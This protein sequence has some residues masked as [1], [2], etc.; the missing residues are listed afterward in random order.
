[1][2]L[3]M[4]ITLLMLCAAPSFAQDFSGLARLNIGQSQ[5]RDEAG[6]LV[7]DLY[8]SQAVPYRVLTLDNPRQLVL[9]FREVD[10]GEATQTGMLNADLASGVAFEGVQDGWSRLRVDL[11]APL[12]I[13]AAGMMVDPNTGAAHLNVRM[14]PTTDESFA[15]AARQDD[16]LATETTP[17]P[18]PM[19]RDAGPITIAIDPGH[20]GIDP[21]ATRGGVHEADLMLALGIEVADAINRQPQLRAV[22]TRDAD[23]FVPIGARMTIARNAGA[24]LLISLHADAL[25]EGNA[26]GASVYTLNQDGSDVAAARMAE[27]HERSDLLGGLDLSGQGDKVATV[28]MDLARAQSAPSGQRFADALIA[29]FRGADARLNSRPRREGRLAVL[30]AADFPSVLIEGGFLSDQI[31]RTTL[32]SSKG[33]APLVA[34][35]TNAVLRWAEDEAARAPLVRQ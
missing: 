6:D 4:L 14:A 7:V 21:G 8:L 26:R 34:G 5:V 1:M 3:R 30:M 25:E 20:G 35:I 19:P 32:R 31:D 9:D 18:Q 28:L 17:I 33:R 16:P 24:D 2:M 29:G 11:V 12:K 13:V 27:R 22:L 23:V 15:V 10:W